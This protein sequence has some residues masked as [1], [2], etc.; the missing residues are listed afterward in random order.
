MPGGHRR[1]CF[2]IHPADDGVAPLLEELPAGI[3]YIVWQLERGHEHERYHFQG[4]VTFTN[5]VSIGAVKRALG[6]D[7]AHL[8]P[9]RGN[10]Q[11]CVDYCTKEDTRV[12][13]PWELGERDREQG[14]RSDLIDLAEAVKNGQNDH[15][16]ALEQP[17]AYAK[18]ARHIRD[19]RF[20]YFEPLRRDVSTL[21]ICGTTGCGKTFW[22]F[23]HFPDLYRVNWRK[24]GHIWWDGYRGQD[25][26]LFDDFYGEVALADMLHLLDIYPLRLEIKGSTTV[27]AWTKVIITSN[28]QAATWYSP[29][30]GH[31]PGKIAALHRRLTWT[32]N[33][34][35]RE[36]MDALASPWN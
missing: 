34:N 27:A 35:S 16:I 24:D 1:W 31:D 26:I 14:K 7:S 13:G 4:Y 25:V 20:A 11:Q 8:E 15:Q 5:S 36:E 23:E 32:E 9:A 3:R 30:A 22:C 29:L 33:A 18:F 28:A 17:V 21:V 12:R 2:T 10:D 19:L 6:Y